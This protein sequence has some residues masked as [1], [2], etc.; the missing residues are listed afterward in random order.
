MIARQHAGETPGA[1]IL[2]GMLEHFSRNPNNRLLIWSIPFADIDG[3][4]GGYYG[5]DRFPYDLN[6][7]WGHPP[8][9]AELGPDYASGE[10]RRVITYASRWETPTFADYA[11]RDLN[12]SALA[13]ETPYTLCG[14]T[15]MS[16]KQFREAGHRI[17]RAILKRAQTIR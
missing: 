13:L 1:W 15:L 7:A 16:Q 8:I 9:G 12:I 11:Q 3:V 14:K 17:A 4:E 5:K 10:F 6:R 2:D